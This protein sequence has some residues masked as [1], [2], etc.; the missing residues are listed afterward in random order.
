MAHC[1]GCRLVL[2]YLLPNSQEGEARQE[3]KHRPSTVPGV[4]NRLGASRS[5]RL[6]IGSTQFDYRLED[7]TQGLS[8]ELV[9]CCRE[10]DSES[11]LG[12]KD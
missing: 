11:R 8:R 2:M 7:P 12:G 10:A 9:G 3:K 4:V 5:S 6:R 1:H